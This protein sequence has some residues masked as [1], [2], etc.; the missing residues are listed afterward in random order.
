[1][2]F[3]RA[4]LSVYRPTRELPAISF[5]FRT[6]MAQRIQLTQ[7][8]PLAKREVSA[9][10][11]ISNNITTELPFSG[12]V[13]LVFAH[14]DIDCKLQ[15]LQA[16]TNLLD[17]KIQFQNDTFSKKGAYLLTE[18][19]S[20]ETALK[21]SRR[22]ISIRHIIE[23]W[24]IADSYED[25]IADINSHLNPEL[26]SY[27]SG[28]KYSYAIRV[29]AFAKKLPQDYSLSIINKLEVLQCGGKVNLTEPELLIQV[30]E[31]YG[32]NPKLAPAKPYRI[33][34]GC[35]ISEGQRKLLAHYSLEKR[36]F[37]GNTSLDPEI[38]FL[39]G[40]LAKVKRGDVVFDPFVG[41]GSAL[42][43]CAHLGAYVMGSD[44][45]R[46]ILHGWSKC[47]RS[48]Q[49]KRFP[50][51]CLR[52][53]LEKYGLEGYYLDLLAA[54]A[55]KSVW[56]DEFK[57][58]AILTDPPYGIREGAKKLRKKEKEAPS[59]DT[60]EVKKYSKDFYKFHQYS[61]AD[62]YL[63]LFRFSAQ[64]LV[65]GGR[66][67]FCFP[68]MIGDEANLQALL[69]CAPPSLRY[70]TQCSQIF[71]GN[72]IRFIVCM[73]KVLS[74]NELGQEPAGKLVS[75]IDKVSLEK[76]EKMN[77]FRTKYFSPNTTINST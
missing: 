70:I 33:Y 11:N 67:V 27:L 55:G 37:I 21:L 5:L 32:N 54:D 64:H 51:E 47:T 69:S 38:C 48:G 40:N 74:D 35:L 45:D 66:L 1:M 43:S 42:V 57:C 31:D 22:S 52:K 56:R 10:V 46:K 25:L 9:E 13:L 26:R 4:A 36:Y 59:I 28:N 14:T 39:M 61:L 58:D 29:S 50:D 15:E 6:F 3:I 12:K 63:D 8:S 34:I 20:R 19:V 62:L 44:I 24:Y 60:D 41:T 75:K 7:T 76:A 49:V 17:L 68:C 23:V 2:N 53:N 30:I 18:M 73:E 65:P 71:G 77:T 72:A 16:L